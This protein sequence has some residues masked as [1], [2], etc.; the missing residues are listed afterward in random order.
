MPFQRSQVCICDPLSMVLPGRFWV[1]RSP[2]SHDFGTRLEAL[3]PS[4]A[5][6]VRDVHRSHGFIYRKPDSCRPDAD[7]PECVDHHQGHRWC[8]K[9][10]L[11]MRG[12]VL[13]FQVFRLTRRLHM[14]F[15]NGGQ[16]QA[17][18]RSRAVL[19][20][21][22]RW[23]LPHT[24][25]MRSHHHDFK[26]YRF[27]ISIGGYICTNGPVARTLASLLLDS[28]NRVTTGEW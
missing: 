12:D 23:F 18:P 10:G 1:A 25:W 28:P 27:T 15:T 17:Q 22:R 13:A 8:S 4:G 9:R 3:A 5:D 19:Q 26:S 16:S 2:N 20:A 7:G 6:S 11:G 14:L 21:P 24:P